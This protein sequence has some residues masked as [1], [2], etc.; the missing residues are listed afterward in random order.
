MKNFNK[1]TLRGMILEQVEELFVS[2]ESEEVT[3][4][5]KD[6]V[7]DQID[8][9]ILKFEKDSVL[10]DDSDSQSLSESLRNMSLKFLIEQDDPPAPEEEEQEDTAEPDAEEAPAEDPEPATSADADAE[11][12]D[13]LPKIPLDVDAFTKRV[14]R[15]AMN[16][17]NLLDIKTTIVNRAINFLKENYDE[18]HVMEMKDILDSQFDFD[19]DGGKEVPEAPYAAG[20]WAGGTGGLGGG[21]GAA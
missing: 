13:T 2:S 12:A 17:Q 8:S 20:A 1:T 5:E 19:L 21:G 10:E 15:L 16:Y 18:A 11:I 7:D 14:A 4:L 9:F 3:R 6:S